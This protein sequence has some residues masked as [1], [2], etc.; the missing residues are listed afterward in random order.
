MCSFY[1]HIGRMRL[2]HSTYS[3]Y[4]LELGIPSRYMYIIFHRGY[5]VT[6]VNGKTFLRI[7]VKVD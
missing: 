5:F 3:L 6:F 1:V 7:S 4:Q 2:P